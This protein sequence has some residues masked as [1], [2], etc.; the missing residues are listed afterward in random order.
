MLFFVRAVVDAVTRANLK[1]ETERR[2]QFA[3]DRFQKHIRN[4]K[5]RL[6]TELHGGGKRSEVR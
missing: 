6:V 1:T 3:T 5:C 2:M 4:K